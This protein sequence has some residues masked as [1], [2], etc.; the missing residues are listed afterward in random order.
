MADDGVISVSSIILEASTAQS[1]T[2]RI[3]DESDDSISV[4]ITGRA[5]DVPRRL[6]LRYSFRTGSR[7]IFDP[8]AST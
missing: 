4:E 3:T 2:A 6:Q 8:D 5:S 7:L 1:F